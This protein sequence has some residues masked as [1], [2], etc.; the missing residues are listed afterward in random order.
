MSHSSSNSRRTVSG[1]SSIGGL[2]TVMVIRLVLASLIF[3][4]SLILQLPD[5]L[6]TVLLIVSAIIAGYDIVL[7]AAEQAKGGNIYS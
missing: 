7:Q 3:A 6:G 1:K 5:L 4:V 2:D